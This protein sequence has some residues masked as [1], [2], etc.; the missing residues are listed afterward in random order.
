[1]SHAGTII[2]IPG[3]QIERVKRSRG[4]EVWARPYRRPPCK[5][6]RSPDLRIKATHRRTVKHTRQGNQ[7][8]TLHLRVPKYHCQA[9]RRYFRHP[10]TGIRPRYRAS[11]VGDEP[12][13]MARHVPVV[14]ARDRVAGAALARSDRASVIVMDDGF[15]NPALAKDIALAVVDG[16][17]G[18][19]NGRVLPAGPLRA[20]LSVQLARTDALVVVGDG[21]AADPV[22]A[23]VAARGRPVFRARIVPDRLAAEALHGQRVLAFAGIGDPAR[24]VRTLKASGVAVVAERTFPD[25]H[26]YTQAEL[27]ELI[28]AAGE[29]QLRLVTTEKDLSRLRSDPALKAMATDISGFPVTLRFEDEP[30]LCD[31]IAARLRAASEARLPRNHHD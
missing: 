19:G 22:I 5:H 27:T 8:M 21:T 11:E 30:G 4:I 20:P 9:C 29:Q 12:L 13:M 17:R 31:F 10:F 26:P 6:C 23:A 7:V 28:A 25:H 15:Q 3:L 24:F 1:M 18:L 16:H 2:G 14:V